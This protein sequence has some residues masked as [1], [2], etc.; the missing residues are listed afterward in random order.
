[1]IL[2][3]A[4][5]RNSDKGEFAEEQ[6]RSIKI[7]IKQTRVEGQLILPKQ[8]QINRTV[9]FQYLFKRKKT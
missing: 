3:L 2:K 6:F 5:R 9:G 7:N 8:Y 4:I 1:M